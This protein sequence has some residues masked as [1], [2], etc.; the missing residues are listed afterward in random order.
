MAEISLNQ[1]SEEESLFDGEGNYKIKN[2]DGKDLKI[3]G[4]TKKL[5]D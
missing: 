3:E 1:G 4:P 2:T 5:L